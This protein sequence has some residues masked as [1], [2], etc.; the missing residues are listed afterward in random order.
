MA[1]PLTLIIRYISTAISGCIL[2]MWGVINF[3]LQ[4]RLALAA[5]DGEAGVGGGFADSGWGY[6]WTLA[7][8]VSLVP[9]AAGVVLLR[10]VFKEANRARQLMG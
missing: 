6:S 5:S 8:I 10:G 1:T 2:M 7:A 4:L 3:T 9:F